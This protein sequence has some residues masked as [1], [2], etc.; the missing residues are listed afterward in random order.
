MTAKSDYIRA[1]VEPSLKA[2]VNELLREM[3]VSPTQVV[4]MLYK[5]I[6]RDGALPFDV[7]TTPNKETVRAIKEARA[8]KG[9]VVCKD[10]ADMFDKL[11]I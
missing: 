4:T 9:L 7:Y 2:H 6:E 8:G 5:S 11:G 3:G 1:R 10:A